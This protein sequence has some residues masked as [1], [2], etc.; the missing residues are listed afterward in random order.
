MEDINTTADQKK[1]LDLM[2]LQIFPGQ[3]PAA[4]LRMSIGKHEE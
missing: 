2:Y 1:T 3:T 4:E